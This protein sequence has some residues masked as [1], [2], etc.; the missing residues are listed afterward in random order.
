MEPVHT[1]QAGQ[2]H[3]AD[4]LSS[5]VLDI[6]REIRDLFSP[7]LLRDLLAEVPGMSLFEVKGALLFVGKNGDHFVM[8]SPER[9][10]YYIGPAQVRAAFNL[11]AYD[12]GVLPPGIYRHGLG[13]NGTPWMAVYIPPARYTLNLVGFA[14]TML[15]VHVPLP[16]FLFA[17]K[18]T[19]YSIW[20]VKD[21]VLREN[22]L[23]YKAPL[24]NVYA[25]GA[26]CWGGNSAPQ[27]GNETIMAAFRLFMHSKFNGNEAGSCSRKEPKDVRNLLASLHQ[28]EARVYPYEDLVF[29]RR[30][31][32]ET[33]QTVES[34]LVEHIIAR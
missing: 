10:P 17:G 28:E 29:M 31:Y 7:E 3:A 14:P 32:N 33:A 27:V 20:A 21:P 1:G 18:G 16:G 25:N 34:V 9:G 15:N 2:A 23:L 11:M 30:F 22:T 8:H 6:D 24:P 4:R 26:I 12:S 5:P 13:S 19:A